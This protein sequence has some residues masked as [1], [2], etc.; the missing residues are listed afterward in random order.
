[1]AAICAI[2][3]AS[4]APKAFLDV[5]SILEGWESSYTGIKTM[6]VSYSE[7]VLDAKPP[8]SDPHRLDRLVRWQHVERTE[9]GKRYHIR[10]SMAEDGFDKPE[11]I[12]EHAF[13]GKRTQDYWPDKGYG[14]IAPGMTGRDVENK[15]LLRY[16]MLLDPRGRTR[17]Y[18][19]QYPDGIPKFSRRLK[20]PYAT[21]RP[22]LESIAGQLC[23]VVETSYE[24]KVSYRIWVAHD[25]GFLP[26][27][28]QAYA[29]NKLVEEIGVEEIGFTETESGDSWYPAK[30]YRTTD[31]ESGTIKYELITSAFVP[32]VKVDENTFRFEFLEGTRVF[33]RVVGLEYTK[34]STAFGEPDRVDYIKTAKEE[35]AENPLPAKTV[36]SMTAPMVAAAEEKVDKKIEAPVVEKP[37]IPVAPIVAESTSG[38]IG[39]KGIWILAAVV[40]AAAVVLSL[41]YKRRTV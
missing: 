11:T 21:V 30:A 16:Y 29:D 10:Y 20:S 8:E 24:G 14:T 12:M 1:M 23:H 33:D 35:Q 38:F 40:V 15:N 4:E 9:Q 26:M 41:W 6:N 32:N 31:R 37:Q 18:A 28:Y 36:E 22:E 17:K 7:Q 25:K 39:K 19:E 13:D 5:D 3:Y 2:S 27:K 34:G